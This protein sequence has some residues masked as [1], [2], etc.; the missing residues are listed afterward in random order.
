MSG[1]QFDWGGSLLNGNGGGY[2][3][4]NNKIFEFCEIS[5]RIKQGLTKVPTSI[6]GMKISRID[7]MI[8]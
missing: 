2:T 1:W 6:L 8:L 7:P 4:L 3:I 5:K